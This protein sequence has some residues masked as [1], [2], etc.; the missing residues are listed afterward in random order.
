MMKNTR[1]AVRALI[2]FG[3][4]SASLPIRLEV[5]ARV[6]DG[7]S[8][9]ETY[10]SSVTMLI[11]SIQRAR[12]RQRLKGSSIEPYR[13]FTQSIKQSEQQAKAEVT[14]NY[15]APPAPKSSTTNSQLPVLPLVAIFC[16]GSACFYWLVKSRQGQGKSHFQQPPKA[17]PKGQGSRG[18][19]DES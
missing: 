19:F 15:K 16:C 1:R 3:R 13:C 10:N 7:T 2:Y 14:S 4:T 18:K 8:L 5:K 12:P 6:C 17:P 9:R 11:R